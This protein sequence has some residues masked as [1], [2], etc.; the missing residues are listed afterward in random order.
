MTQL[1]HEHNSVMYNKFVN[2]QD[3]VVGLIAYSTYKSSKIGY[4]SDYN[5]KHG[6]DPLP[7]ELQH[8][9]ETQANDN[10][11]AVYR[12]SASAELENMINFLQRD[13]IKELDHRETSLAESEKKLKKD[14]HDHEIRE[15]HCKLHH[16]FFYGVFQSLTATF[17]FILFTIML[18]LYNKFDITKAVSDK[19]DQLLK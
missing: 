10:Q 15:K 14:K 9:R 18:F 11:I 2:D 6:R 19:L 5:Q 17:I 3:D 8:Y 1:L 7:E 13:K 12:K 16:G 4:I